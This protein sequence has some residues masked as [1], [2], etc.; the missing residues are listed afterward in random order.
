MKPF[1]STVPLAS[2][3]FL[4]LIAAGACGVARAESSPAGELEAT[5]IDGHKVLLHPNGRWK[6]VDEAKAVEAK[7]VADRY[8]ENATRPIEAQ[9]GVLGIGRTIMPGDKDYN[10][11]TLNP[12]MR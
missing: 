12:K 2:F 1:F 4:A 6:Y 3:A 9:G 5:T 11:G 7:K 8:P 10:R